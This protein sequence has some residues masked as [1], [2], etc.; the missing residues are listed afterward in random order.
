MHFY[1]YGK[2]T[3]Q[4]LERDRRWVGPADSAV[5]RIPQPLL[6]S[7]ILLSRLDGDVTQKEL[8]LVE[9]SSET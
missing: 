4:C 9:F 7:R 3:G 6:T 2:I 1:V 5:H 8:N